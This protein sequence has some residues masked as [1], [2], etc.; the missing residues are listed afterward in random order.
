MTVNDIASY[1]C[2]TTGD[3]SS[4]A[5]AYAKRA[6]RLKYDTLYISHSWREGMRVL[7]GYPVDPALNGVFFLPFDAE[8]VIFLSL[9]YD[10]LNYCRLTYRE[11]DWIERFATPAYILPGN[12]P[13]FFRAENLAWAHLNPSHFTF[14]TNDISPFNIHIEGYDQSNF[15]QTED[16][17]LQGTLLGSG[18]VSPGSISTVN[19]Y[20]KVTV[21]SKDI[22]QTPLLISDGNGN[23]VSLPQGT[24]E[25]IFTQIILAPPPLFVSSTGQPQPVYVRGQVKLKPDSLGSD[26][27]V[28]RISGVWDA[29]VCFTI[30]SLYRRLQQISKA[31]ATEQEAL[32]H[33]QAAVSKE[34]NQAEFHQQAVPTTYETGNYLDYGWVQRP[35]SW[36]PFGGW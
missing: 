3:I 5:L 1:A 27:S 9:S 23:T 16:F 35:T 31:Q 29:L 22:T 8:E 14:T 6:L 17:A 36:N 7:D 4:D 15:F 26:Y 11:R 24:T 2:D 34:K 30:A 32:Q 21:L 28:P 25:L 10:G 18:A 19:S 20:Q 12:T 13:W 33:I